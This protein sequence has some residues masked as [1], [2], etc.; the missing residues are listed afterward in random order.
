MQLDEFIKKTLVQVV[1]GVATAQQEVSES[2]AKVNPVDVMYYRDGKTTSFAGSSVQDV[3][4]DVALTEM[5]GTGTEGGIGVFLGGIGLGSKG[6]SETQ[7]TSLTR[8]S[9]SVPLMLPPGP[10]AR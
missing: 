6:K 4:F 10:S 1:Q 5:E 7:S 2:G 9:F 3:Q 8:I